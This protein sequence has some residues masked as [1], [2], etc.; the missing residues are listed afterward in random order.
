MLLKQDRRPIK[1]AQHK[2]GT[3]V[4]YWCLRAIFI[5][6]FFGGLFSTLGWAAQRNFVPPK[7][8]RLK[9]SETFY[10]A[11][12]SAAEVKQILEEI[13][14]TAFDTPES[15]ESELRLRRISLGDVSGLVIQGTRLLC[16]GTG[17]CQTW[18]LRQSRDRWLSMFQD[19]A[20]LPSG[21]GFDDETTN[22]VKN[23]VVVANSSAAASK[24]VVYRFDGKFYREGACYNTHEGSDGKQAL[25]K[26]PC[27]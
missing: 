26:A 9:D 15:W 11:N 2:L 4:K 20:P 3:A 23:F 13:E 12:L 5:T 22:G 1:A 17:N 10:A 18:V 24:Y 19:Q 8:N 27:K 7:M 6:V 14:P 25:E 16:G 21:F